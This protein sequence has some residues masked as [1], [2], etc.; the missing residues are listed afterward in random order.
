MMPLE[1]ATTG[2]NNIIKKNG[3]KRE[4]GAHLC[5]LLFPQITNSGGAKRRGLRLPVFLSM[6]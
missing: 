3:G 2:E 4:A 6:S 1:L 5:C